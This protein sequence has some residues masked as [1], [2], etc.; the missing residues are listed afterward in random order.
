MTQTSARLLTLLSLLQAPREWPG[1]ELARRLSVS[2]RTVRND[3]ERLRDLGYPVEATRGAVGGYRLAAGTAMPPLLLD[4]EEAV[5]VAISLRTAAGGA[6]AGVEEAALR[7]LTTLQQVL[8][9]RLARRVDAV[10]AVTAT[11]RHGATRGSPGL[12]GAT[13]G[14]LTAAARDREVVRFAYADAAGVGSERRV[15]P[16]RLVNWGR[17]WYLVAFDVH[18]D[19]WRTFRVDRVAQLRPVGHRF[20]LRPLPAEDIAA[21]VARKTRSVAQP[22]R[23]TVVVSAAADDVTARMGGWAEGGV[24]ALPDGR[25]R[26]SVG[27][28]NASDLAIWLG[29]LDADFEVD[30]SPELA[31]ALRALGSRLVAAAR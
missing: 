8:P 20:A 12:D 2:T 3:V 28:R 7:A 19:D 21:W 27:A 6:V 15:E 25:C 30:A 9:A 5:A 13:L 10:Q 29:F 1:P 14:V 17:R 26:L 31:A 4:D 23:A 22:F 11:V 24:E 16:Y 18:R